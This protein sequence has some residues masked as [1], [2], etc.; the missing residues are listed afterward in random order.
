MYI[1]N[2]N[3]TVISSDGYDFDP[4]VGEWITIPKAIQ[5]TI[6]HRAN[7]NQLLIH[8]FKCLNLYKKLKY[9]VYRVSLMSAKK[10]IKIDL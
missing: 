9:K 3:V 2:H 7:N 1:D 8:C 6:S 5:C 10:C 4:V